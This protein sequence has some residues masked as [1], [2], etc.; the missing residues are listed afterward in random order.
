M[1]DVPAPFSMV[2]RKIFKSF[3]EKPRN[4]TCIYT[5][6]HHISPYFHH[7]SPH[8]SPYVHHMFTIFPPNVSLFLPYFHHMST[9]CLPYVHQISPYVHHIF[10]ICPS[11]VYH[12]STLFSPYFHHDLTLQTHPETTKVCS[13]GRYR[14]IGD[15]IDQLQAVE[16]AHG[17]HTIG[18][19]GATVGFGRFQWDFD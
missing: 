9:I 10:T 13:L 18:V 16:A 14:R 2:F 11:Y 8:V 4:H 5:Y 1:E 7:S 12:I 17:D 6:V 3:H 15:G 19:C